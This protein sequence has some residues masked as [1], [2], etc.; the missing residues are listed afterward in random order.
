MNVTLLTFILRLK[1]WTQSSRSIQSKAWIGA[2]QR[3]HLKFWL[4]IMLKAQSKQIIP[5]QQSTTMASAGLVLQTEQISNW[6]RL[7][8][9]SLA[10]WTFV[11][12]KDWRLS[13]QNFCSSTLTTSRYLTFSSSLYPSSSK[14]STSFYNESQLS[15][16]PITYSLTNPFV[17]WLNF[18]LPLNF[19]C[20]FNFYWSCS[21]CVFTNHTSSIWYFVVCDFTRNLSS[22]NL[23]V[24]SPILD[25]STG[26]CQT[27]SVDKGWTEA[28]W[29]KIIE[30]RWSIIIYFRKI[31]T[32]SERRKYAD[33]GKIPSREMGVRWV[34]WDVFSNEVELIDRV[35]SVMMSRIN[36]MKIWEM[37]RDQKNNDQ[38][39][40][41]NLLNGRFTKFDQ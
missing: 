21:S 12:S 5:C 9:R 26:C 8:I 25:L 16:L 27:G 19:A 29:I 22:L 41:N 38:Q 31:L 3:W 36:A 20:T 13:F 18:S 28:F 15:S 6:V 4:F 11:R 14:F 34:A 7:D 30:S 32:E 1:S 40:C 10:S 39:L 33:Q 35:S 24:Y 23:S 37:I 2:R 17:E